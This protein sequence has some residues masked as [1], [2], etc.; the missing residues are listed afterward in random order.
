[1]IGHRG[2]EP[3]SKRIGPLRISPPTARYTAQVARRHGLMGLN[4][5]IWRAAKSRA[6]QRDTQTPVWDVLTFFYPFCRILGGRPD[7]PT[8]A[9]IRHRHQC[10]FTER[11]PKPF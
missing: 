8:E 5:P 4:D 1:M 7:R 2:T 6:D 9:I 11:L 3:N 10:S